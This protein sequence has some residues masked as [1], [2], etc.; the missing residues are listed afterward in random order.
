M[1]KYP[2]STSS[3]NVHIFGRF[4]CQCDAAMEHPRERQRDRETERQRDRVAREL[5]QVAF[6]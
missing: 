1:N 4:T 5:R 6:S 2:P 3:P